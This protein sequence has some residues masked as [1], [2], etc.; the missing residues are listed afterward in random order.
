[1]I[2]ITMEPLT[3]GITIVPAA[4][5]PA[6]NSFRMFMKFKDTSAVLLSSSPIRDNPITSTKN[7]AKPIICATP[8]FLPFTFLKITGSPPMIIPTKSSVVCKGMA[9][10]ILVMT[11]DNRAIASN[12]PIT[13]GIRS[14]IASLNFFTK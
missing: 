13:I 10:N 12:I 11:L 7:T 2:I 5:A 3:P 9:S 6:R 1:M 8:T 4:S 14:F